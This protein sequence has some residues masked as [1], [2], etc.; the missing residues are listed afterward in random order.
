MTYDLQKVI[1]TH[2]YSM[3]LSEKN[4]KGVK[5]K[6]KRKEG[7]KKNKKEKSTKRQKQ[8]RVRGQN[9]KLK[10]KYSNQ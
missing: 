5:P 7:R 9:I 3:K 10:E 8:I 6:K 1:G 4:D 2:V